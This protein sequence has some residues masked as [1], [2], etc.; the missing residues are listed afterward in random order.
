MT[1]A[2]RRSWNRI[3]ATSLRHG[4]ELC[5]DHA[6]EKLNLSVEGIA[7]GMGVADHW[8][9]YK[10]IQTGRIPAILIRPF[11]TVCGIDFVTRWL[12]ASSGRMLVEIPSG[13]ALKDTDV[14]EL[15]NGVTQALKLLTDFYAG[16]AEADDTVA[17][18]TAHLENVA[19][20]RANVAQ[21]SAPELDFSPE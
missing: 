14:V 15:H 21:H 16:K 8:T 18:L 13:R 6:R 4:L 10:W 19:W 17:A 11:E 2:P 3:R 9:V 7:S 20:H 1:P 5:K 12:V